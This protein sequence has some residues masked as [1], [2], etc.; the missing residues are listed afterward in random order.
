MILLRHLDRLCGDLRQGPK[1]FQRRGIH[2]QGDFWKSLLETTVENALKLRK[3]DLSMDTP[4]VDTPFGPARADH[5]LSDD[6]FLSTFP[7][8]LLPVASLVRPTCHTIPVL[9][10]LSTSGSQG[11]AFHVLWWCATSL[12]LN[13]PA[14]PASKLHPAMQHLAEGQEPL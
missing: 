8:P 4:F 3:F 2:D 9:H 7:R 5:L 11:W 12:W 14:V 1:G 6:I 13:H 10:C